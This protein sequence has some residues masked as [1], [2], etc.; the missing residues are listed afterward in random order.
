MRASLDTMRCGVW[1]GEDR[2][3]VQE[4][5]TPIPGPGQVRVRVEACGVCLTEVHSI[6]GAF[7]SSIPPRVMGHEFGGLVDQLGPDV[8]SVAVGTPVACAGN[9][10]LAQYS[11]A[12]VR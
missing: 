6:Q 1:I 5:P 3:E 7:G 10:G 9:G 4:R 8:N 12:P 2:F 11:V